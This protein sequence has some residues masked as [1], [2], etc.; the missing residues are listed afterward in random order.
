MKPNF[1]K[2]IVPAILVM[3]LGFGQVI[4]QGDANV[5]T[6]NGVVK[7]ARTK[8]PIA[9]ASVF[10]PEANIGTVANLNGVFTLKIPKTINATQFG[11]SHL[12]YHVASFSVASHIGQGQDFFLEAHT[13]LL[14]EVVVRPADPRFLV[15]TALSKIES[16]YPTVPYQLTGFY[17]EAIRQRRDYI[18]ISEAV[19]DV[20]QAPYGQKTQSDRTRII[21]GR[22]SGNVKRADT[23]LL[24]LQGGPYVSMLLDIVKNNEIMISKETIDFYEYEFLDIVKIEDERNYVIG[25]KPNVILPFP[26][27][28]GK[29]YLSID[30]LAITMAE[31]SLDL[32]DRQKA[33]QN[34]VVR[35]PATLRFNPQ[36][37]NYLVTYKKIGDKYFINY[38]RTEIEFQ[39]DWRRRLFRTNYSIMSEMAITERQSENIIRF[40]PRESFRP[41]GI[42]ADMVPV[43]FDEDFWGDYNV[44]EPEE[45]IENA[46][47]RL[48]RR[49]QQTSELMNKDQ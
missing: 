11:I 25:F 20:F 41:T 24:K 40:T 28:I 39:A 14:D 6:I 4:A 35:K 32:S 12:G 26:L 30:N 17:R 31:F 37:T 34:F 13:V 7:D 10:V 42:L 9:F 46:I 29:L 33:V 48:N 19:V 43:Y 22:K 49:I 27:Y 36:S 38:V 3:V 8:R 21:Q 1:F 16:N 23:L 15:M 44:I 5:H 18:S 47:R 2:L 45:S